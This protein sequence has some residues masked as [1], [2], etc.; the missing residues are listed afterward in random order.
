[1]SVCYAS[2]GGQTV[3]I[4]SDCR[5]LLGWCTSFGAVMRDLL[6]SDQARCAQP[7][8]LVTVLSVDGGQQLPVMRERYATL[9][10]DRRRRVLIAPSYRRAYALVADKQSLLRALQD[11]YAAHMVHHNKGMLVSASW[12]ACGYGAMVE[13]G[14]DKPER[15]P[16]LIALESNAAFVSAAPVCDGCGDADY[17]ADSRRVYGISAARS[18]D[19][20]PTTADIALWLRQAAIYPEHDRVET[21]KLDDVCER[22][23][24]I[25]SM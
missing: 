1:M 19:A 9:A 5:Q 17:G 7:D 3:R 25:A 6:R 23:A 12:S 15:A 18:P 21:C 8:L 14:A 4:E 11:I 20:W 13:L 16:T 2:L 10:D 22:V 24:A